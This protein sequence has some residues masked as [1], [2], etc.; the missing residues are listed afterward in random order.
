MNWSEFQDTAER[1]AQ[2][3]SQGDWRSAISRC[4]Y[5]VFHYFREFF[6]SHSLDIGQGGQSHNN[7]YTG[8]NNC[9]IPAVAAIGIRVNDLRLSRVS[10]DYE[11]SLA[12]GRSLASTAVQE[13]RAIITDFQALLSTIAPSQIAA[14]AKTYLKSIGRLGR[15]P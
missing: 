1:L 10:A 12:I 3:A 13:A 6:L 8:L 4:Y 15:T 11:L 2:R 7:L 14:G 9:G 5:A